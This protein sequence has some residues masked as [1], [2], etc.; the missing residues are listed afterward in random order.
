MNRGRHAPAGMHVDSTIGPLSSPDHP[1]SRGEHS[2]CQKLRAGPF[3]SSPLT[4][5]TRG[6]LHLSQAMTAVHP[7]SRGEHNARACALAACSGSSPLTRGTL[8]LDP[9][10]RVGPRFIP[11]HAGNTQRSAPADRL[12]PVHPRSR[13]EHNQR[14][15]TRMDR[16]GSSPL[17]RGT[18]WPAGH[19]QH[20]PRFIPAHAGN[21]AWRCSVWKSCIGSSPL[22]RGTPYCATPKPC[23]PR[24]I[25]A[26]AG[27]T[28]MRSRSCTRRLVHPRSRGEHTW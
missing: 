17:T 13:G 25:P 5:G 7:R 15:D 12:R 24:F 9:C 16:S 11:A 3:G 20:H 21:T 22:T 2:P 18:P 19:P 26:H 23:I 4:R 1:R 10:A 6:G 28:L 8:R 14:S 27:N